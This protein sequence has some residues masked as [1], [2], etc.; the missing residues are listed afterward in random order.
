MHPLPPS[1]GPAVTQPVGRSWSPRRRN[2]RAT[3]PVRDPTVQSR[4][5]TTD[6][7]RPP[8]LPPPGG[9]SH[10]PDRDPRR[11]ARPQ[12]RQALHL[13][14]GRRTGRGRRHDARPARW[15]GRGSCRDDQ[16][17]AARASR[18]HDHDRGLQRLLHRR[19]EAPRRALGR[20]PRG[21]Q[22]GRG[23]DRQGLWQ[24]R[25]PAA[26]VGPLGRQVLHARDDGHG[27]QPRASTRR[28]SRA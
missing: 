17:R 21:R 11:R 24:G 5:Y 23:A 25:R 14:V 6:P 22:G 12:G 26:R 9:P 19:R 13:R 8:P 27:P 20:R 18:V 4:G 28:R 1:N 15:Q 10:D 7:T 16:R 2:R 3:E